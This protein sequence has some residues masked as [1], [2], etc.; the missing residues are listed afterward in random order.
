MSSL[1]PSQ[2]A[3]ALAIINMTANFGGFVGNYVIGALKEAF[4]NY[5]AAVWMMGGIMVLAAAL[6]AAFPL[7]WASSIGAAA[8]SNDEGQGP[9]SGDSQTHAA[10]HGAAHG[11]GSSGGRGGGSGSSLSEVVVQRQASKDI[12]QQVPPG[13][14]RTSW[15]RINTATNQCA[16]C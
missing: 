4:G 15:E 6:V 13:A 2:T 10:Q 16:H 12:M 3:L 9:D 1:T 14:H 5:Y 8:A 11:R 7:S